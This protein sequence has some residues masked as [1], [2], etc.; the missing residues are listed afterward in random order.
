MVKHSCTRKSQLRQW[1][2]FGIFD[3]IHAIMVVSAL[4]NFKAKVAMLNHVYRFK[5]RLEWSKLSVATWSNI[6]RFKC[7]QG[8]AFDRWSYIP[9]FRKSQLRQWQFSEFSTTSMRLWLFQRSLMAKRRLPCWVMLFGLN[10]GWEQEVICGYL[11]Q[12]YEIQEHAEG[13][14]WSTVNTRCSRKSQL[15]LWQ[16]LEFSTTSMR[17]WLFQ[18]SLIGKAKAA[19]LSHVYRFK[20]CLYAACYLSLPGAILWDLIAHTAL[21]LIDGQIYLVPENHIC[22][23]DNFSEF[24]TTSMRLWLFQRSLF[25]KA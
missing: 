3:N 12:Y 11:E 20:M 4:T 18:R 7:T 17:L 24:S 5:M 23:S 6:M 21:H 1:Q 8:D 25:G 10:V 2:F 16:F 19:V 9:C 15:R 13:C 14:I 22:D